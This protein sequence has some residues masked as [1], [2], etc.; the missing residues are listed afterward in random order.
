VSGGLAGKRVVVIGG[1]SGIGFA[2][3]S[4]ALADGAEV[5]VGSSNPQNVE[6]AVGRLGAGASGH[7]VDVR[8]EGDVGAFFD[9]VGPFDHLAFTA[10]DWGG[11]GARTLADTDLVQ[12]ANLF[13]VRFW[14]ALAAVKHGS[15]QLTEGGS[16]TL[17]NGMIA[18]RPRK[19]TPISTAMAGSIEHLVRGLAVDLAPIRVN[20]VCPGLIHTEVWNSI[21]EGDRAGRFVEMTSRQLVPRIGEPSEVAEAY[22]YLMRGGYTTGQVL[23]VD[24]GTSVI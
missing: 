20:A 19:G 8:G 4:G 1:S 18:H 13:A 9:K 22:L 17:T 2:I 11:R 6:A 24:G 3:A 10:G 5:V 15:K 16:I 21:P 23:H 12:A 7:A 14:G